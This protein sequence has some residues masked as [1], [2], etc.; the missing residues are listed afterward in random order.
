[1]LELNQLG[2][3][4]AADAAGR[5]HH[6]DLFLNVLVFDV[7]HRSFDLPGCDDAVRGVFDRQAMASRDRSAEQVADLIASGQ[8]ADEF[9]RDKSATS[10]PSSTMHSA[11]YS[12][13]GTYSSKRPAPLKLAPPN[14]CT[15]LK[16][17]RYT[18]LASCGL[19]TQ[20]T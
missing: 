3:E 6:D 1:M 18:D 17:R 13:P 2:D 10:K 20:R 12:G 7:K 11:L 15:C 8:R 16:I 14:D 9:R 5:L 19:S 4:V